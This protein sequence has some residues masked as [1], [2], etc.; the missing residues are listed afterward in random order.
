MKWKQ[1]AVETLQ[2][3]GARRQSVAAI[4]RQI[5]EIRLRREGIRS[6]LSGSGGGSGGNQRSREDLMVRTL[7]QERSLE[8]R[9]ERAKLWVAG[10]EEALQVLTREEMTILETFYIQPVPGA[11]EVLCE[12]L[13]LERS[14]VYRRKDQA[15]RRFILAMYGWEE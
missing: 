4:S 11:A 2:C 8:Q 13:G 1:E 3:Y 9:L 5:Q 10:V 15:L 6:S 14:S 12:K 7:E